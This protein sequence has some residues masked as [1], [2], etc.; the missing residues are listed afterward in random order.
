MSLLGLIVFILA[1]GVIIW[2]INKYAPIPAAFKQII[3]WV[4]IIVVVILVLQAFGIIDA[5]RGY[6]VPRI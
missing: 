3:L 2:V 5:V 6:R 4:G 1:I